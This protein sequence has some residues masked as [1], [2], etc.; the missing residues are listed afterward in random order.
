M[1]ELTPFFENFD[2]MKAYCSL[3]AGK[4]CIKC[5]CRNSGTYYK[6]FCNVKNI[7]FQMKYNRIISKKSKDG[8][9]LVIKGTC[10]EHQN[11][12]P[13]A[14][15]NC[16]HIKDPKFISKQILPI[17]EDRSPSIIEIKTEIQCFNDENF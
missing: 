10:L 17:F 15:S 8:Y 11:N 1:A 3:I 14:I 16:D 12:C 4:E 6:I 7:Q 9:F 2:E 13:N 5:W